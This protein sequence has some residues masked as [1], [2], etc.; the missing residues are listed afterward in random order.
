MANEQ[1]QD[2]LIRALD[3]VGDG[4]VVLDSVGKILALNS[5][6]QRIYDQTEEDLLGEPITRLVD[7]P[8][9]GAELQN[10]IEE[11]GVSGAGPY[12]RGEAIRDT[13]MRPD[14]TKVPVESVTQMQQCDGETIF[15]IAVRDITRRVEAEDELARERRRWDKLIESGLETSTVVSEDGTIL[16][17]SSS[18]KGFLGYSSDDLETKNA[19]DFS[20][21]ADLERL[22]SELG[23]LLEDPSHVGEYTG[24]FLHADGS[25]RILELTGRN[26]LTDPDVAGIVIHARDVTDNALA[27]ERI[28][29]SKEELR[30]AQEVGS[31]GIWH[32]KFGDN[33]IHWS[34]PFEEIFGYT[35]DS[36]DHSLET[37][38]NHIHPDD[39][40]L[41]FETI[42]RATKE[43]SEY[44]TLNYRT[45]RPDGEI[46]YIHTELSAT[47]DEKGDVIGFHGIS[48]DNTNAGRALSD[49]AQS[50]QRLISAQ[51]IARC[52]YW[53]LDLKDNRIF[54]SDELKALWKFDENG[55]PTAL[56]DSIERL[57]PADRG[58]VQQALEHAVETGEPFFFEHR[59][60]LGDG[61]WL[62]FQERGEVICNASGESIRI[63][64]V[65]LEIQAAKEAETALQMARL[66]AENASQ[67]K[68]NFLANMSHELRTPLNAVIGFSDLLLGLPE[69]RRTIEKTDEYL[70]HIN[71][72]GLHLLALVNDIL[73]ISRIE[74]GKAQPEPEW[75]DLD[76]ILH[77][78]V[79]L[80]GQSQT[81]ARS[82]VAIKSSDRP[83]NL[84]IDS[85]H[86]QQVLTNLISNALKFSPEDEKVA[87]SAFLDEDEGLTLEV[88]DE[89]TG[90]SDADLE[91]ATK[92]FG[93]IDNAFSRK[94]GGTGLGLPLAIQLTELNGG[95]LIIKSE[96]IKGTIIHLQFPNT[97]VA[98]APDYAEARKVDTQA[99][100]SGSGTPAAPQP[101]RS[102]HT[103]LEEPENLA[104]AD[105]RRLD[106]P[107]I[108]K[109]PRGHPEWRAFRQTIATDAQQRLLDY[110]LEKTGRGEVPLRTSIDPMALP[111]LLPNFFILE[112]GDKG[113]RVRLAG[114]NF[115]SVFG[116]D[117]THLDVCEL[118]NG[119]ELEDISI[120]AGKVLDEGR[121]V[122]DPARFPTGPIAGS[123]VDFLYL[124]CR[125]CEDGDADLIIGI[126]E[127][128]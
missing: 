44:E 43:K 25:W 97:L 40:L 120:I 39:V 56:A 59:M 89:G 36:I 109:C 80:T 21:P 100:P 63:D 37:F 65:A 117:P 79:T 81:D 49:L 91:I 126:G 102:H 11:F 13:I 58:P 75:V 54:Y 30:R 96:P 123:R 22:I 28:R 66:D 92:P 33:K 35:L 42:D 98:L 71:S 32:V 67:V 61:S 52:G 113:L 47:L 112:A 51:H 46:G 82:R 76:E 84:W 50:E 121:P 14:G 107:S 48:R 26:M 111:D 10:L 68:S 103:T 85:R 118:V 83:V 62:W 74:A 77:Q 2:Y 122:F 78:S 115:N 57:I 64:G 3:I 72:S 94:V 114:T 95:K 19:L 23:V 24:R 116:L 53:S 104:P 73:D 15:V 55:A 12:E 86:I 9:R 45:V 31:I 60:Q 41:T 16:F 38:Y 20:D 34:G 90:M 17:E 124:P 99:R 8:E 128:A 106:G 125:S 7:P 18:T 110:W 88:H 69:S 105:F 127:I 4:I 101:A 93:Q 27:L 5:A 108:L 70:G 1:S 6:A 87:V 119:K 29:E